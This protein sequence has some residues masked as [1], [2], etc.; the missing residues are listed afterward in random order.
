MENL[1]MVVLGK[2]EDAFNLFYDLKEHFYKADSYSILQGAVFT[3]TDGRFDYKDGFNQS[4]YDGESRRLKYLEGGLLGGLMGAVSG[5]Y[6]MNFGTMAGLTGAMAV[7]PP[8]YEGK[9]DKGFEEFDEQT[10]T[11]NIYKAFAELINN[12]EYGVI[13]HVQEKHTSGLDN[14][15]KKYED[16]RVYRKDADSAYKALAT[17]PEGSKAGE[18]EVDKEGFSERVKEKIEEMKDAVQEQFNHK[19]A[20]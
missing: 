16:T 15:I 20:S 17:L 18:S 13:L 11:L 14:R 9:E 5:R 1:V 3:K 2:N 6:G 12:G 7:I 10:D 4:R 19:N 8:I